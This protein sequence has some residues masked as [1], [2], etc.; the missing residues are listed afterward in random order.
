MRYGL[1]RIPIPMLFALAVAVGATVTIVIQVFMLAPIPAVVAPIETPAT[2]LETGS[3]T[4]SITVEVPH[5]DYAVYP[6]LAGLGKLRIETNTTGWYYLQNYWIATVVR[7]STGNTELTL[8]D[9]YKVYVREINA[10]HAF[11]Y[12]DKSGVGIVARKVQVGTTGWIVYHPTVT[13][14]DAAT[15]N[16]I[17][18]LMSSLNLAT[19]YVFQPKSDYVTYDPDTKTFTVYLDSVSSTG[20]VTPKDYYFTNTTS[21]APISTPVTVNGIERVDTHNYVLYP[22]WMLLY[23]RFT[24]STRTAFT[25]APVS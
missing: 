5:G 25:V 3:A 16:V 8:S 17:T 20:S 23:H 13:S 2:A 21:F 19:I 22:T 11:V 15:R 4:Y 7:R 24:S 10:T 6:T 9:N 18:S 14:Y 12:F 1:R